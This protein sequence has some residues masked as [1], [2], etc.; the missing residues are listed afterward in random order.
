[1]DVVASRGYGKYGS[2]GCSQL[3]VSVI[4]RAWRFL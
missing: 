3:T 4:Q 2:V 1:M